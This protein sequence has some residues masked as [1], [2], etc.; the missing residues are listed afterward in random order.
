M[1]FDL[2]Y[3]DDLGVM[4]L[5]QAIEDLDQRFDL[6]MVSEY[7]DESLILLRHLLCWSLHDVVGFVKNARRLDVKPALEP[8]ISQARK[9]R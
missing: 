1:L 3:P 7:L 8:Q 6:V 2:G 5:R 4:D 9:L